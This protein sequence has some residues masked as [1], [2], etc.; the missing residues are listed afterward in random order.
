[1]SNVVKTLII[2]AP[3]VMKHAD[4]SNYICFRMTV[5][6]IENVIEE[7]RKF[8]QKMYKIIID[9]LFRMYCTE[10]TDGIMNAVGKN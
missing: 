2:F 1:M 3:L 7:R 4:I 8:R 5:S 6:K 9:E 10:N